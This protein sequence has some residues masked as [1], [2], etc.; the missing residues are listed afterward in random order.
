MNIFP[1]KS[2]TEKKSAAAGAAYFILLT[3]ALSLFIVSA[4]V[5]VP[6]LW[7][8]FYYIHIDALKLA[9]YTPWSSLQI[10]EAYDE[11]MDFCIYG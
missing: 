2:D 1:G 7:R 3:L 10:K 6:L 11:M 4:A 9:E 5:A 8:G